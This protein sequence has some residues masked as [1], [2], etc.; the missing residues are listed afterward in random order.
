MPLHRFLEFNVCSYTVIRLNNFITGEKN[1]TYTPV[2]ICKLELQ[3]TV[4]GKDSGQVW[5]W[6]RGK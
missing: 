2:I 6:G 1:T 5:V 4:L 3:K